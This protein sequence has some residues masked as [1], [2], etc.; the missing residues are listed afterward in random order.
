MPARPLLFWKSLLLQYDL[1][2]HVL[3]KLDH[4]LWLS[5]LLSQFYN[6]EELVLIQPSDL[7]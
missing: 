2:Q 6:G 1:K 5:A 3:Y 4:K 7:T